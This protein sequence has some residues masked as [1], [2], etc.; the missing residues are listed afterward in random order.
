M[1]WSVDCTK[2][3]LRLRKLH[4]PPFL[5]S[6]FNIGV[7]FDVFQLY[8]RI[9]HICFIFLDLSKAFNTINYVILLKK[10]QYCQE[11]TYQKPRPRRVYFASTLRPRRGHLASVL[12]LVCVRTA[13]TLRPLCGHRAS[14]VRALRL[15]NYRDMQEIESFP[16]VRL[17][18]LLAR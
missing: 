8:I 7:H 15:E 17:I 12:R 13:G 10:L 18:L 6:L 1:C 2:N 5:A 9:T 3:T 16:Y 4:K 11:I 14:T